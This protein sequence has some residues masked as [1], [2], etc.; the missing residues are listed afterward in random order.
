MLVTNVQ[1]TSEQERVILELTMQVDTEEEPA[2]EHLSVSV[3]TH[4]DVAAGWVATFGVTRVGNS[5][6]WSGAMTWKPDEA[7]P[8]LTVSEVTY[9]PLPSPHAAGDTDPP[10]PP[11]PPSRIPLAPNLNLVRPSGM[12]GNWETGDAADAEIARI[13]TARE[14]RFSV[15]LVAPNAASDA[16]EWVTVVLVDHV[17]LTTPSRVPG[18]QLV[19]L[20]RGAGGVPELETLNG[21]LVSLGWSGLLDVNDSHSSPKAVAILPA[22]VATSF[23]HAVAFSIEQTQQLFDIVGLNRHAA[24]RLLAAAVASRQP[25]GTL[26]TVNGVSLLPGYGGNLLGGFISGE[27]PHHLVKQWDAAAADPRILLWLRL[28]NEGTNDRR[29]DYQVFRAFNLLE[30]IAREVVPGQTP[31]LDEHGR[32]RLQPNNQP[33]TSK[34]ARGA[35]A[36]LLGKCMTPTPGPHGGSIPSAPLPNNAVPDGF[37]DQL[38]LWVEVRNRVAHAGSWVY[39]VGATPPPRWSSYDQQLRQPGAIDELVRATRDTVMHVLHFALNG[40]L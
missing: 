19:P 11:T 24:P 26:V 4:D 30:G 23:D 31:I 16:P 3:A 13:A 34:H 8:T 2:P 35:V 28:H 36:L 21:V 22:V 10:P 1:A 7:P 29:W 20:T 40:H 6:S 39:P 38:G 32:A 25:D 14:A 17:L 27:D 37:W 12:T 18:I 5:A 33:Y 9:Q 15:P